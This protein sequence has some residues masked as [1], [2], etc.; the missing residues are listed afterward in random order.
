MNDDRKSVKRLLRSAASYQDPDAPAPDSSWRD[1]VL[2]SVPEA[3]D[4]EAARP[5][6]PRI[7]AGPLRPRHL[8]MMSPAG[9]ALFGLGWWLGRGGVSTEELAAVPAA[10]WVASAA[11]IAGA[12]LAWYVLP[13]LRYGRGR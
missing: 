5:T 9:L 11:V 10:A 12:S 2:L 4:A 7:E 3:A 6:V 1:T 8:L 13:S